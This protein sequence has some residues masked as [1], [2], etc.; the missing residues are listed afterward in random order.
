MTGKFVTISMVAAMLILGACS[1]TQGKGK[2]EP[3]ISSPTGSLEKLNETISATKE[4]NSPLAQS[5]ESLTKIDSK[6]LIKETKIDTGKGKK[7]G[8]F[9]GAS[10]THDAPDCMTDGIVV[11]E[12]ETSAKGTLSFNGC[13]FDG[14]K[15]DGSVTIDFSSTKT[16]SSKNASYSA[17]AHI[18]FEYQDTKI[19]IDEIKTEGTDVGA[20]SGVVYTDTA[21]N[22][23]GISAYLQEKNKKLL[24]LDGINTN[25][26][27]IS[28]WNDETYQRTRSYEFSISGFVGSDDTGMFEVKT[29]TS[30]KGDESKGCPTE[31]KITVTDKDGNTLS[32][33]SDG[34]KITTNDGTNVDEFDCNDGGGGDS[35]DPE[36]GGQ[37]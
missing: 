8:N 7:S 28:T 13:N 9:L 19:H 6:K 34:N 2:V 10:V 17:S 15:I 33:E 23:F 18:D 35:Q 3:S 25:S 1:G 37:D 12:D 20:Y 11:N 16:T 29:P 27:V 26:T 24:I 14:V 32:V 4:K 21:S 22:K 30:I 5:F 36:H 31:G